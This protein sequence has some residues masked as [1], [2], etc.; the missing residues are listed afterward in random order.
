MKL[1]IQI[2]DWILL[3]QLLVESGARDH[4]LRLEERL[5][6]MQQQASVPVYFIYIRINNHSFKSLNNS[7]NDQYEGRIADL[8]AE[9]LE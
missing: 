1:A 9:N 8:E 7:R 4:V 3:S 6:I 2:Y 5:A